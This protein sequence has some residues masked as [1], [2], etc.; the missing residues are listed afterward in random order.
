MAFV[1]IFILRGLQYLAWDH[2]MRVRYFSAGLISIEI[3]DERVVDGR[4]RIF[5]KG[6]SF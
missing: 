5:G 2:Y 6:C 4:L 1:F 3:C